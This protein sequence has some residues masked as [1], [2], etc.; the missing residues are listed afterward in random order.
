MSNSNQISPPPIPLDIEKDME[1]SQTEEP[2]KEGLTK[3]TKTA[4]LVINS[5][6]FSIGNI[7]GP[8]LLRLYFLRGGKR[9][10]LSSWLETGGWPIMLIPLLI[11]YHNRRL[12]DGNTAKVFF[13]TPRLFIA[14]FVL[15]ILTGMDDYLY[16]FGVSYLPV[17]TSALLISSQLA[18][19][20]VFALV[21][22]KQKFSPYSIN[23]VVLLT[24]GAI[25]LGLH[26]NGD[27]P[28]NETNFQY[29]SGF[30]MTIGAAALYGLVLPLVELTY[31][32]AK[33]EITYSLVMEM[34]LVL[35]FFATAF[36]TVG[37]LVDNDFQ[38]IPREAREF[39]LGEVKYYVLLAASAIVW[40]FFF[41]GMVGVISSSSSLH[42]GVII[43]AL[44]PVIEVLAVF[45]FK[46]KFGAEKG[47]SLA[48]SL[49]G[50]ASYLYGEMR[51]M[52]KEKLAD[53]E[54]EKLIAEESLPHS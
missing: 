28:K 24:V 26:T 8:L 42:A 37:M 44:I 34:Q 47:V 27:R 10:W 48:L 38:V 18:F 9:K 40:Q 49:W 5:I 29:W 6:I 50:F 25:I 19:T 13:I 35:S 39:E 7:G 23:S 31:I 36:C 32:K 1:T 11:S 16:A 33:Q 22:V 46:E 45:I 52:K 43:A 17:S 4:F 30:F 41:L 3:A 12:K 21:I 54:K 53:R 20:A 2:N 14:C 15:G 51:K